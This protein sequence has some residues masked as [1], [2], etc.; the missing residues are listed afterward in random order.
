M[1]EIKRL[2]T[3]VERTKRRHGQR[4]IEAAEAP[5]KLGRKLVTYQRYDEAL[6]V[7]QQM[8]DIT[9]ALYGEDHYSTAAAMHE[10]GR[11]FSHVGRPFEAE[12]LY[13]RSL[14]VM[15]RRLGKRDP[16]KTPSV[17]PLGC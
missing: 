12:R 17:P 16:H 2:Q 10:L 1:N 11:V 4:S 13:E 15:Q 5:Q 14:A 3:A 6:T 7:H 9:R 8:L